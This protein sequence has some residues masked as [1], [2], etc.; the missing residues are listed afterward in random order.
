MLIS[1]FWR[2]NHFKRYEKYTTL[3]KVGSRLLNKRGE[4]LPSICLSAKPRRQMPILRNRNNSGSS[5]KSAP[6]VVSLLKQNVH[7]ELILKANSR[8]QLTTGNDYKYDRNV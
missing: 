2:T 5:S 8:K 3:E 4:T 6:A 7:H 1:T